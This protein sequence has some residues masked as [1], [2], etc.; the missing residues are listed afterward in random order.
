MGY[1]EGEV[2]GEMVGSRSEFYV[3]ARLPQTIHHSVATGLGPQ[4]K[5]A[6]RGSH[7]SARFLVA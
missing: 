3:F 5:F 4:P 7:W 2:L 6:G 1:M